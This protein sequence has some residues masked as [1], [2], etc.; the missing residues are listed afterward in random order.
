MLLCRSYCFNKLA[1]NRFTS[2][3]TGG[4]H[5]NKYKHK[6]C[7]LLILTQVQ[8]PAVL[9]FLPMCI[10]FVFQFCYDHIYNAHR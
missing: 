2:G 1:F 8:Y 5:Q 3:P 4:R 7:L 10:M 9:I 6:E